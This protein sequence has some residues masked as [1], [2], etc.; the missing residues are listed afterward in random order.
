MRQLRWA[1]GEPCEA[2]FLPQGMKMHL[3]YA[4]WKSLGRSLCRPW[5]L[6]FTPA[7]RYRLDRLSEE[8]TRRFFSVNGE[9]TNVPVLSLDL[10][11][12]GVNSDA[13]PSGF[14]S[15][16]KTVMLVCLLLSVIATSLKW[17]ALSAT[18]AKC[19]GVLE[20]AAGYIWAICWLQR[21]ARSSATLYFEVAVFLLAATSIGYLLHGMH[22]SAILIGV[23]TCGILRIISEVIQYP[24]S[25]GK[26]YLVLL[27]RDQPLPSIVPN[28]VVDTHTTVLAARLFSPRQ[29]ALYEELLQG[30]FPVAVY[31]IPGA[32]RAPSIGYSHGV[33]HSSGA[34]DLRV[35]DDLWM[36]CRYVL[37][38]YMESE[39][40]SEGHGSSG[41]GHAKQH[42]TEHGKGAKDE[43]ATKERWWSGARA[44]YFTSKVHLSQ[45]KVYVLLILLVLGSAWA[46]SLQYSSAPLTGVPI[47]EYYKSA[48][49]LKWAKQIPVAFAGLGLLW[50]AW[51]LFYR[52][53]QLERL[54]LWELKHR[55]FD[56]GDIQLFHYVPAEKRSVGH[57][58][59][60]KEILLEQISAPVERFG[61]NHEQ[62]FHVL[63]GALLVFLME[64]LHI[65]HF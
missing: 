30:Q 59:L 18:E 40:E 31:D 50:A 34:I 52:R 38:M 22:L 36:A 28:Y 62:V 56:A 15:T 45:I 43:V 20:I 17:S 16:F 12:G 46:Y 23:L 3:R 10:R 60:W 33:S 57:V 7:I 2:F 49:S 51:S 55:S 42:E 1:P 58:Y 63:D 21:R 26:V 11:L 9:R 4:R 25:I 54:K 65:L 53:R 48:F 27:D 39:E 29:C 61:L 8:E 24:R 41:H 19:F 6:F 37:R 32:T 5:Q 64:L 35:V 44:A 13:L 14:F 47:D